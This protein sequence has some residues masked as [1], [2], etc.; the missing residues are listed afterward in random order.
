MR[1]I[2]EEFICYVFLVCTRPSTISS[3]VYFV[4]DRVRPPLYF[5]NMLEY[6]VLHIL[7]LRSKYYVCNIFIKWDLPIYSTL[8]FYIKII[9]N[10]YIYNKSYDH[11]KKPKNN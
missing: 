8:R 9:N 5:M 2:A 7:N 3:L 11:T 10:K 1:L 6:K 4:L